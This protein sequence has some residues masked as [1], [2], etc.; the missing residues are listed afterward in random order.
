[1]YVHIID[2]KQIILNKSK[3]GNLLA[4]ILIERRLCVR[5]VVVQPGRGFST[6]LKCE[7]APTVN[8]LHI[9]IESPFTVRSPSLMCDL[10]VCA[11]TDRGDAR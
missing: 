10:A 4:I 11:W 7:E 6:V 1:M 2:T 3:I 5:C 8:L 9:E